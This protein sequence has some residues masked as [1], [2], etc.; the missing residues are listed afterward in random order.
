MENKEKVP[1]VLRWNDFNFN[2]AHYGRFCSSFKGTVSSE[3]GRPSDVKNLWTTDTN[4]LAKFTF[5][6]RLS[7]EFLFKNR[8]QE[9]IGCIQEDPTKKSYENLIEITNDSQDSEVY[10]VD[11]SILARIS[12]VFEAMLKNPNNKEVQENRLIFKGEESSVISNFYHLLD[13]SSF[14]DFTCFFTDSEKNLALL[15]LIFADKYDIK[16]LYKNCS[17]FI[18]KNLL[19]K[20][21]LEILKVS[22]MVND[23]ILFEKAMKY[24]L[25]DKD[26]NIRQCLLVHPEM[27]TEMMDMVAL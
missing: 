26:T 12:P 16:D 17:R 14:P 18:I 11:K 2:F 10:Q 8:F 3:T 19:D 5:N 20:N 15:L 24:F 1:E 25:A 7:D 23:E 22:N 21:S 27:I 4:I 13:Q 9:D 6:V